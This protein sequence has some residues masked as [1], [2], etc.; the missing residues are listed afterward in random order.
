MP[1]FFEPLPPPPPER[2][3]AWAPPAWDRPSEGTL[4]AIVPVGEIVHRGDDVVVSLDHLRAYPNGFTIELFMLSNPHADQVG[5]HSM[6]LTGAGRGPLDRR[7]PR[8][9]VR[10]A[11]GRTG[12][13]GA[14]VH[15][16]LGVAR[17]DRGVPT[18]PI[19]SMTSSGGGSHGYRYGVWVFPLPPAGPLE[20]HV[21]VPMDG[22]ESTVVLDGATLREAS[23]RARVIWG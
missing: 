9:G 5:V 6:M 11:D 13:R 12:G 19:V 17:D 14:T 7:F 16:S 2:P 23:E 3:R 8:I 21:A 18:D 10:F 4:P 20:V 1:S 15:G 22:A